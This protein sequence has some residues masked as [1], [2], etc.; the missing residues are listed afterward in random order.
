MLFNDKTVGRGRQAVE[1]YALFIIMSIPT[2]ISYTE[3]VTYVVAAVACWNSFSSPAL[4]VT[5]SSD[6]CA[7]LTYI[8][9]LGMI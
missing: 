9:G 4:V 1:L 6:S 8:S 2:K 5:L 3:L 7:D